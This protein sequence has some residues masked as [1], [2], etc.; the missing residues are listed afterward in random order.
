[1][2]ALIGGAGDD[3]LVESAGP[4]RHVFGAAWGR[5]RITGD[6]DP[7]PGINNDD[8]CFNCG[9]SPVTAGLV[10]DLAAGTAYENAAGPAGPNAVTWT[11]G[12]IEFAVGGTGADAI[13]GSGR[14]NVVNGSGGADSI[15]VAGDGGGDFVNCGSDSVTD[16][17]TKDAG[18]TLQGTSCNGDTIVTAP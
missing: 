3:Q 6:G 8:V 17:V 14:D 10:I 1:M 4:D 5:D 13:A 18:D 15:Y 7:Q 12:I 11:P 9:P 2:E 16:T